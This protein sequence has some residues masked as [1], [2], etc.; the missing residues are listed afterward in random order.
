MEIRTVYPE[1]NSV[2]YEYDEDNGDQYQRGNLLF[3]R[4]YPGPRMHDANGQEFP[5]IVTAYTYEPVYNHVATA[6]SPNG[7]STIY[8]YDYQ[9]G[10]DVL[11][12]LSNIF[13]YAPLAAQLADAIGIG[14][15]NGDNTTNQTA[16]RLIHIARPCHLKPD[17]SCESSENIFQYNEQGLLVKAIDADGRVDVL[18]YY[19]ACD[20][21][22]DGIATPSCND[23]SYSGGY[24][25]RTVEDA[26]YSWQ[27][28]NDAGP[29]VEKS[30]DYEYTPDGI[31]SASTNSLG[32]R[33]EYQINS[34]GKIEVETGPAPH[35]YQKR[36]YYD[37]RDKVTRIEVDNSGGENVAEIGNAF[38]SEYDYDSIGRP[39]AK[40]DYL[41]ANSTRET[42][43]AYDANSNVIETTDQSGFKTQYQYNERNQMIRYTVAPASPSRADFNIIYND[44][45]KKAKYVTPRGQ[46][47]GDTS[48]VEYDGFDRPIRKTDPLGNR[49]ELLYDPAGNI[50]EKRVFRAQLGPDGQAVV[51]NDPT[52][53]LERASYRYDEMDNLIELNQQLFAVNESGDIIRDL[54][55]D[56]LGSLTPGDGL[57]TTRYYR[58]R[59][60]RIVN[61]QDDR[62]QWSSTQYDPLSHPLLET[63]PAGNRVSKTYDKE[64]NLRLLVEEDFAGAGA[65]PKRSVT[66][67]WYDELNRL[68]RTVNDKGKEKTFA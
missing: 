27:R 40:R 24:L 21:D 8:S 12:Q 67:M 34:R 66:T 4:E 3:K 18:E 19:P 50:I 61:V 59:L 54:N 32:R 10:Y 63:D 33:T 11:E 42:R 38:V 13:E 64:G 51:I 16:G 57:V 14:D 5:P 30:T 28:S 44:N 39:V 26:E 48:T 6:T 36:M 47:N 68:T 53:L 15:L 17:G 56:D 43:Y 58:D 60:G 37:F 45:G 49:T 2:E 46:G 62:R 35:F 31:V 41:N 25:K 9:E 23:Q 7:V 29:L 20:P 52:A 65:P 22:G 55:P 1:G